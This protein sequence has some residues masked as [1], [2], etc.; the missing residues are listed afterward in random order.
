MYGRRDLLVFSCQ[1]SKI[2]LFLRAQQNTNALLFVL[3]RRVGLS[4]E[5]AP[6]LRQI[7][8]RNDRS[9]RDRCIY[10][11]RRPLSPHLNMSAAACTS[12]LCRPAVAGRTNAAAKQKRSGGGARGSGGTISPLG[13]STRGG[14]GGPCCGRRSR[15]GV[16]TSAHVGDAEWFVQ[17]GVAAGVIIGGFIATGAM[18]RESPNSVDGPNNDDRSDLDGLEDPS[19]VCPMCAGTGRTECACKRWSDDEEGCSSCGYTG[20]RNCPACRGGGWAVR[21]TVEIPVE[22]DAVVQGNDRSGFEPRTTARS[23]GVPNTPPNTYAFAAAAPLAMP[24]PTGVR[25]DSSPPSS[26]SSWDDFS[27]SSSSGG[28]SSSTSFRFP[29]SLDDSDEFSQY[30]RGGELDG[31]ALMRL[32]GLNPLLSGWGST[33]KPFYHQVKPFYPSSETVLPINRNRSTYQSKPFHLSNRSTFQI[34][35]VPLH[36]GESACP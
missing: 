36:Q 16:V 8:T 5:V 4:R 31:D 20:I 19:E 18:D 7:S 34:Q 9:V 2:V 21:V 22:Q 35:P 27:P 30:S 24:R 3:T 1:L 29:P 28:A 32:L 6:L 17:Q 15:A 12:P 10:T 23:G 25:G 14:G 26:S 33:Y 11:R 13:G